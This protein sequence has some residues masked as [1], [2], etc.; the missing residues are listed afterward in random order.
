MALS[1]HSPKPVNNSSRFKIRGQVHWLNEPAEHT[2]DAESGKWKLEP[3][4]WM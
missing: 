3:E 4:E 2:F 1:F